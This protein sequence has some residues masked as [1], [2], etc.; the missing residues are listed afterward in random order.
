MLDADCSLT[1]EDAGSVAELKEAVKAYGLTNE[2]TEVCKA[3]YRLTEPVV[4]Y[5]PHLWMPGSDPM[6]TFTFEVGVWGSVNLAPESNS[7]GF[8]KFLPRKFSIRLSG[9]KFAFEGDV[10][11]IRVVDPSKSAE[12][13]FVILCSKEKT[14]LKGGKK[15]CIVHM[16]FELG[17]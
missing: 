6:G 3:R 1:L 17:Q 16:L 14:F 2:N 5:I 10:A 4:H 7:I 15:A 8:G 12:G 11:R 9:G 13:W